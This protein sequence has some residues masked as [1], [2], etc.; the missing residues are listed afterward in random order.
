MS[1]QTKILKT[2]SRAAKGVK[3]VLAKLPSVKLDKGSGVYSW[4]KGGL[5]AQE[6]INLTYD[7]PTAI[8]CVEIRTQGLYGQGF[9]SQAAQDFVVNPET[10]QT[11]GQLLKEIA[12]WQAQFYGFALNVKHV[13][14][15]QGAVPLLSKQVS[16]IS[17]LEIDRIERKKDGS[18]IVYEVRKGAE[19]HDKNCFETF[20]TETQIEDSVPLAGTQKGR[21]K[22]V[23]RRKPGAE[24]YPIP[25]FYS[26]DADLK[27]DAEYSRLDYEQVNNGFAP[28]AILQTHKM[29]RVKKLPELGDRTEYEVFE[30]NIQS[31][32]GVENRGGIIHIE[33]KEV[34]GREIEA[35]LDFLSP[36][37]ASANLADRIEKCKARVAMAFA[38]PPVLI[39]LKDVS[40]IGDTKKLMD[41]ITLFNS[42]LKVEQDMITETLEECFPG[43]DF[44][45]KAANPINYIPE[46]VL[47]KMTDTE[48]RAL[49]GLP[50]QQKPTSTQ[51]EST[52]NALNSLSPLVA[53]KVLDNLTE[54]ELRALIGLQPK[55]PT[56]N[57][58]NP[59]AT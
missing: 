43:V 33:K 35:K 59:P 37:D 49:A 24:Q 47:A 23:F 10:K 39:G 29:D 4:G 32:F 42:K 22:Y 34:N 54:T 8:Q 14:D 3:D 40:G 16:S 45:I 6:L 15:I 50:E 56:T 52:I 51:A 2:F 11:A 41:E 20:D 27:A 5:M 57:G 31:L 38:C 13:V 28:S 7:S 58:N 36:L 55:T 9:A 17:H 21:V 30:Q 26:A 48:I 25:P 18:F 44:S 53:T 46:E 12:A 1:L 19:N